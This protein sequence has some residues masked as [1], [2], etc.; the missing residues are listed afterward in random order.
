MMPQ[1]WHIL[2]DPQRPG[3]GSRNSGSLAALRARREDRPDRRRIEHVSP[4]VARE[5]RKIPHQLAGPALW[6]LIS[7]TDASILVHFSRSDSGL[8]M[9]PDIVDPNPRSGSGERAA[10]ANGRLAAISPEDP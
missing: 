1:F 4:R 6:A 8:G 3:G 10:L 2:V 9:D 7:A 5:S